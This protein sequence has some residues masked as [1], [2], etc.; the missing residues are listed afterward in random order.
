MGTTYRPTG[1]P[2]RIRDW[3][4]MRVRLL[5]DVSTMGGLRAR[6]GTVGRL[7][8]SGRTLT[9]RTDHCSHCNVSFALRI[10]DGQTR[11]LER[12]EEA[13]A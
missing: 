8:S 13:D 1:W 9:F 12:V 7:H 2:K 10:K 3:D 5:R 6:K 4:G 11:D